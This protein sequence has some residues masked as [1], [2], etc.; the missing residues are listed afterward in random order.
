MGGA[1]S[2]VTPACGG[3]PSSV[4]MFHKCETSRH[5]P[6]GE[7][8]HGVARCGEYMGKPKSLMI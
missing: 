7:G 1:D 2:E 8:L 3:R 4:T 5:L 6:Q